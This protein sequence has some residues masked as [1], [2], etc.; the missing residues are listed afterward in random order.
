[1]S[2]AIWWPFCQ[3]LNVLKFNPQTKV[4]HTGMF[5]LEF[6]VIVH[7]TNAPCNILQSLFE[8]FYS[9]RQGQNGWYFAGTIFK[10][11]VLNKNGNLLIQIKLFQVCWLSYYPWCINFYIMA[12]H[13]LGNKPLH[14][15]PSTQP[16]TCTQPCPIVHTA[17]PQENN[18]HGCVYLCCRAVCKL[19]GCVEGQLWLTKSMMTMFNHAF[20][21]GHEGP[22]M[23]LP[24]FADITL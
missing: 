13:Q 16:C 9:L 18:E 22:A 3:S 21:L 14:G 4:P 12:W 8:L 17:V 24:S 1:M 10:I 7:S 20:G 6:D 15:W 23:L 11:F 2:S 5:M 19:P